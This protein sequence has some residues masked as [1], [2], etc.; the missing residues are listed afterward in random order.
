MN[1]PG[2]QRGDRY[3]VLSLC[4]PLYLLIAILLL[5]TQAFQPMAFAQSI[6]GSQGLGG[7]GGSAQSIGSG[8]QKGNGSGGFA[9]AVAGT[10]YTAM[11]GVID[12]P[13]SSCGGSAIQTALTAAAGN[14]AR[15]LVRLPSNATCAPSAGLTY[16]ARYV[17]LD[18][19]GATIDCSGLSSGTCLSVTG[20]SSNPPLY[21]QNVSYIRDVEIKGSGSSNSMTGMLLGT[22]TTRVEGVNVHDFATCWSFDAA[23]TYSDAVYGSEA[24]N[25]GTAVTTGSDAP[26]QAGEGIDWFQGSIF[27]STTG[28]SMLN[29]GNGF[30]FGFHGTH[31]DGMTGST[32]VLATGANET[33]LVRLYDPH[34]EYTAAAPSVNMIQLGGSNTYTSFDSWGRQATTAGHRGR[35]Y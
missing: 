12:V 20:A 11:N 22:A 7:T 5:V 27:N 16:D 10:D 29:T 9:A 24:W 6:G 1:R 13:A 25:C 21:T 23:N 14:V 35:P 32:F 3:E 2:P 28:V 26:S 4:R 33:A 17:S 30:E 8:I 19:R 15:T 34:I 18:G 31:F